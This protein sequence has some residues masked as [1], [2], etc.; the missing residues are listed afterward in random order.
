MVD[1]YLLNV[2]LKASLL[3]LRMLG[4]LALDVHQAATHPGRCKLWILVHHIHIATHVSFGSAIQVLPVKVATSLLTF[5][6]EVLKA[7]KH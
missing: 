7:E 5:G 2:F 3:P 6:N 1:G 4:V